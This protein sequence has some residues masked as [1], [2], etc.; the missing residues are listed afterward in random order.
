MSSLSKLGTILTLGGLGAALVT[1][2]SDVESPTDLWPEGD[3]KVLQVKMSER[4]IVGASSSAVQAFAYGKHPA[5]PNTEDNGRVPTAV[6]TSQQRIRIILDELL[7]GNYLEQILCRDGN[8]Q[9]VP[10][11]ATPDD[12]AKCSVQRD[13]LADSCLSA[14]HPVCLDG[15]GVPIGVQDEDEDG[16]SDDTRFIE[17]AV[18]IVCNSGGADQVIPLN[19]D[20]SYWQ[21]SGNQQVP[22][23]G[24]FD[25]VGPAIVLTPSGRGFPT[26]S[27]CRFEFDSSVVDKEHRTVC[28]PPDDGDYDVYR[29]EECSDGL[30]EISFGTEPLR[31]AGSYP[32]DGDTLVPLTSSGSNF[33]MLVNFNVVVQR[34]AD[35]AVDTPAFFTLLEDGVERTDITAAASAATPSNVNITVP[36]GFLADTEYMLTVETGATDDWGVGLPESEVR[37]ITFTTGS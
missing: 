11:G 16:T 21:P 9:S 37:T 14:E 24:G 17:G 22:A 5:F 13:I 23:T 3:P 33:V 34:G 8:Y 36:G 29:F 4:V 10:E 35:N 26:S 1:G 25:A 19:L 30:S 6:A 2:C 31:V 20:N 18:D 28:A 32:A 7:I 15:E 12:I 27:D